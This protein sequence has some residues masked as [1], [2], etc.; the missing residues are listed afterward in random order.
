MIMKTV[1][2]IPAYFEEDRIVGA[3]NDAAAFVDAVVV[4]DDC[5]LDRTLE[6]AKST[7]AY[8]LHHFVNC[9]QGAAL[10]T[11]MDYALCALQ[12]DVIVHFDA[13]GQMQGKDIPAMLAP[14]LHQEVD[15][16]LGSRFLGQVDNIP[17]T[18]R[19]V[20]KAAIVFTWFTSAIKLSDTHNGF[21]ALSR[22][23]AEA[24]RLRQNRMAHASEILDLIAS[25]RLSYR[26]VPVTI[27]YTEATLNKP[28]GQKTSALFHIAYD[29]MNGKMR[30]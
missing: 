25:K 26:E 4:V 15:V 10:Q 8:V 17:L 2:I 11:G 5:S 16:T 9:G 1:A 7:S 14:I 12:A 18:R 28:T 21:R 30:K 24:I 22:R 23:A 13:D 20:L 27:R 19:L 29:F 3:V 6:R